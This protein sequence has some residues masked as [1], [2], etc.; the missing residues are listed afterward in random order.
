[1]IDTKAELKSTKHLL[2]EEKAKSKCQALSMSIKEDTE[3]SFVTSPFTSSQSS[4]LPVPV[5][6]N[7]LK[8][9]AG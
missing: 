6:D 3:N 1:M 8:P 5:N 4:V 2:E 9:K 7:L